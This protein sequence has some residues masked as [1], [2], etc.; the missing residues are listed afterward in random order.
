MS[1]ATSAVASATSS[2]AGGIP[3]L[4]SSFKVVGVI[5]AILSGGYWEFSVLVDLEPNIISLAGVLIGSSFV[6]KKKGLLSSQA[7]HEL[8]EGVGYLK[9]PMWWTGMTMMILGEFC[10]FAAY[11]F[12]PAIVVTPL[13]A[14]SVVICAILSSI[15]LKETLTFFGW[16]GCALCIVGSVIIALNGPAEAT[17]GHIKDFQKLFLAPAFL[18]FAGVLIASSL[19]IIIY[20]IPRYGK[21]NMLWCI[22]VCSMIGG[23]SVSTTTGLGASIVT[24]IFLHE[25]QF[26]NVFIYILI[27]FVIVTLLTEV[28]YLNMALALFNTGQWV[29]SLFLR[30]NRPFLINNK[31]TPTYYVIF[32]GFALVT[33]VV[34]YQGLKATVVQILTVV[35]GFLVICAGITILQMSKVDPTKLTSLDR[36]STILLQASR[37]NTESTE[38]S[39]AGA[40]DPGMDA[41]RGSFGTVGSIIR[42]RSA[43]RLSQSSKG[44]ARSRHGV[45]LPVIGS[46]LPLQRHQLYDAPMPERHVSMISA[47]SGA[48]DVSMLSGG[49]GPP[50]TP[51]IKFT[52][53]DVAH[54]YAGPGMTAG[55]RHER[56]AAHGGPSKG[57]VHPQRQPSPLTMDSL[58]RV[59]SS[60]PPLGG[61]RGGVT[62]YDSKAKDPFGGSPATAT[63]AGFPLFEHDD[64]TP[65]GGRSGHE[66]RVSSPRRYPKGSE[67][68]DKDE[69]VSLVRDP[70]D[71]PTTES[72]AEPDTD[73]DDPQRGGIRLLT[74]NSGTRI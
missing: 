49:S 70:L 66:K 33:S 46:P 35:M 47:D 42:A 2:A 62:L 48:G 31:V 72:D 43:R 55:A 60:A 28:Y 67:G 44:T 15:F 51:T 13:G 11:A 8:G 73:P 4:P 25:N 12:I 36:R 1:S 23:L 30:S 40:E 10:N 21:K 34:L 29:E 32:T 54:Y 64:E 27:V 50:R 65:R 57:S 68:D 37:N 39:V 45:G 16:I 71:T 53:E 38:K 5:L 17:V 14:L 56:L 7:G 74:S 9:S 59:P 63:G 18:V 61:G 3:Q 58:E 41:L 52:D 20:F 6:F 24:S 26:K 19:V 69:S 22:M